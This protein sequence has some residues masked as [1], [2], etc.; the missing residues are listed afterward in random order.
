M[1]RPTIVIAR[2]RNAQ[3]NQVRQQEGSWDSLSRRLTQ[4]V[5][6]AGKDGPLWS[7][8]VY[9]P[10]TTRGKANVLLVTCL[11][12]DFD[13][14]TAPEEF[15]RGWERYAYAMHTTHTHTEAHPKWRVVFP[16]ARPVPA[17][18]WPDL[19][20]RLVKHFGG[21]AI[22]KQCKDAS[23]IYYLPSCAPDA[24]RAAHEQEGEW[25]DPDH[26]RRPTTALLVSKAREHLHEGRNAAGLWLAC[27]MRDNGYTQTE[28][29]Q[30]RWHAEV[31]AEKLNG[32]GQIDSYT[33]EEWQDTVRKVF[34][35][36]AREAW[37]GGAR[38]YDRNDQTS[39][40]YSTFVVT[41]C[42]KHIITPPE[43]MASEA[44]YGL[45]GEAVEA[46]SPHTESDPAAI[47]AS[48][49]I[50]A[51]CLFGRGPHIY[52]DG[53][54]HC[55][56]EFACLVGMSSVGRKGTATRRTDEIFSVVDSQYCK[57][58]KNIVQ[59]HE[60][61]LWDYDQ[62]FSHWADRSIQGLGSGEGLI[63]ALAEGD[64][65]IDRDNHDRRRLVF[66]EEFAR[67]LTVMKREGSIL[68]AILRS[69]W[70]GG[71][72]A[73]RTKGK[74][75]EA[76]GSHVAILG[77]I[78]EAELRTHLRATDMFNGFANRFL[79]I[80]T[81]RSKRLPFGGGLAPTENVVRLLT[82]VLQHAEATRMVEFDDQVREMWDQGGIY[83]LL[84]D[85]PYGLLGSVTGRAEAHVTRL[86]LLFALL[87]GIRYI[88]AQHLLAALAVWD[89]SERSCA[90]LFGRS[91]GDEYAD[92]I[93][94]A[95]AEAYPGG[96]SRTQ[97]RNELGRNSPAG[98]VPQAL[99]LLKVY[100]L[101]DMRKLEAEIGRPVEVWGLADNSFGARFN[102]KSVVSPLERARKLL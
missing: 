62:A 74:L 42:P 20:Q 88:H 49:L 23:R 86:A 44:Y 78:T 43:G 28:V 24:P 75:I 3:D 82:K 90:Y 61:P 100:G 72:L 39:A 10:N 47:L 8:T 9:R 92:K 37:S 98:R 93:L 60:S 96:L 68:S 19:W 25:L 97:I 85:R 5:E 16:F 84:T 94:E 81:K 26:F 70:D 29:E 64:E 53:A 32:N 59:A 87:D 91:T 48:F 12:L 51:G 22:D 54:R 27:Q 30:A 89:Y 57:Q 45:A 34:G 38:S 95:L 63:A 41:S 46:I 79:W 17:E 1:E 66:E 7:P 15:T 50:S 52:R 71:T 80:C 6:R 65:E 56:N 73:A 31:P 33:E 13:S 67:P 21:N 55:A 83:E 18:E 101:A 40:D 69:A 14:G 36:P 102:D 11:V 76:R 2:F 77:H 99:D 4:H 35:R 58:N